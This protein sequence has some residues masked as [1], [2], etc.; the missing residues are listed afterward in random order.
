M[1]LVLISIIAVLALNY[2]V[3]S[4]AGP[5]TASATFDGTAY[6]ATLN[7]DESLSIRAVKKTVT[8]IKRADLYVIFEKFASLE[9]K[10]INGDGYPDLVVHYKS[11]I[12]NVT[13][14]ALYDKRSKK[15]VLIT[16]YPNYPASE[17]ILNSNFYYSY[18]TGGCA[19]MDWDSDLYKIVKYKIIPLGTISGKGCESSSEKLGIY[20]YKMRHK[21]EN[22]IKSLPITDLAKG[23]KEAFIKAYWGGKYRDF[24][25]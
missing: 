6:N 19:D 15:F 25:N 12:P 7:G 3:K 18:H 10:D 5:R 13:D 24:I 8:Y 16:G 20:I 23:G 14:A 22:L 2:P 9:F 17:R 21:K 4:Y 1:K 11:N